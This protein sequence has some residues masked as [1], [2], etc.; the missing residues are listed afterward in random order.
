MPSRVEADPKGP[1]TRLLSS[2]P[3]GD[4]SL[5][6]NQNPVSE[7]RGPG[8][9]LVFSR[10]RTSA[11]ETLASQPLPLDAERNWSRPAPRAAALPAIGRRRRRSL[12]SLRPG[13]RL[14]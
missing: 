12:K 7:L 14:T 5:K 3:R 2:K 6:E 1:L 9:F 8:F 10:L 11:T 4:F 13:V